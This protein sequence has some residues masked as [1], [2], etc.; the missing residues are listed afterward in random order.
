[1]SWAPYE[2]LPFEP[3]FF[4]GLLRQIVPSIA[5]G[6]DEPPHTA[7]SPDSGTPVGRVGALHKTALRY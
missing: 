4:C 2:P 3:F 5:G 1:M 7:K 6:C